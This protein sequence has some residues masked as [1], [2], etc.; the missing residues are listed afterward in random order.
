M[1][2]SVNTISHKPWG[3]SETHVSSEQKLIDELWGH[4]VISLAL[5]FLCSPLSSSITQ[6][7]II[8]TAAHLPSWPR[9]KVSCG[10][11]V[12]VKR[13]KKSEAGTFISI[14]T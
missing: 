1:Q 14:Y 5:S 2:P 6:K 10:N 3:V 7:R 13:Q 12:F 9:I 11:K 8:N 4:D